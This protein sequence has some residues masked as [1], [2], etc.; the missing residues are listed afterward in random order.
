MDTRKTT[1]LGYDTVKEILVIRDRFTGIIQSY[2]SPTK[3]T[4]DV[5][6]AV[7][8]FMGRRTIREAYSDK[9]RQFVKG[10]EALKNSQF[11]A[12]DVDNTGTRQWHKR[13]QEGRSPAP[14]PTK[15]T[16]DHSVAY[17]ERK[18]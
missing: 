11:F 6:R 13:P 8:Y 10:M 12:M 18:E 3:N 7:K 15:T 2:P 5:V 9:A 1:K 14:L 17:K 4:E 16:K